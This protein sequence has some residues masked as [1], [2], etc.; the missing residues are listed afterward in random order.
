MMHLRAHEKNNSVCNCKVDRL[1]PTAV[2]K[3]VLPRICYSI[4]YL[5]WRNVNF[6]TQELNLASEELNSRVLYT[7]TLLIMTASRAFL[8][9]LLFLSQI[10]ASAQTKTF[11]GTL[12]YLN[13]LQTK[14]S[15]ISAAEWM[16]Y[17]L[18]DDTLR[19][20][21][22]EENLLL[23]SKHSK[24]FYLG[25]ENKTYY[26]QEGF[27]TLYYELD[28]EDTTA[29]LNYQMKE[30]ATTIA[31]YRC[32]TLTVD[33]RATKYTFD[34]APDLPIVRSTAVGT[35]TLSGIMNLITGV[36][37][38]KTTSRARFIN[39]RTVI[40]VMPGQVPP[41]TFNLPQLPQEKLKENSFQKTAELTNPKW[42]IYLQRTI[43][44]DLAGKYIK[45]P[46][47]QEMA[48]QTVL[49]EFI[50][51]KQ[52]KIIE[53]IVL[54]PTEVHSKLAEEAI[55]VIA[56]SPVWTPASRKGE[57]IPSVMVQPISFVSS[58]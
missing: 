5:N 55:R 39:T 40:S 6:A 8:L 42:A 50:V 33:T 4:F 38:R 14:T 3:T 28:K 37:L 12:V 25:K 51:D 10:F 21:M 54:N 57:P 23:E 9:L 58:Y 49:V 35:K 52:G 31:G 43:N 7:K 27:D 16:K 47:K 26:S 24:I 18:Q 13:N 34:F 20:Q 45:I 41:A 22:S 36:I 46:R 19:A 48:M 1:K 29:V 17:T 11:T 56:N 30:G 53:P 32:N 15:A 44:A 2:S